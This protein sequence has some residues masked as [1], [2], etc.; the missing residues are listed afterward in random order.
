MDVRCTQVSHSG[1]MIIQHYTMSV[2]DREGPVYTG[3]TYFGFFSETALAQQV[4]IRGVKPLIDPSQDVRAE[5]RAFP[6]EAPFPADALRMLDEVWLYPP[7]ADPQGKPLLCGIKQVNPTDW[8]FQAHFYQDPVWPGS[9]GLEAML[10]LMKVEAMR[11]FGGAQG[12]LHPMVAM[13]PQTTHR[14]SYRGQVIPTCERVRVEARI[15]EIDEVKKLLRADGMLHVDGRA[16]Y[17]MKDFVLA[18][19]AAS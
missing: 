5:K 2:E 14:W 4:G 6:R 12:A 3:K 9:L 13:P 7:D 11:R 17:E 10:Q 8:F 18:W 15:T 1:G 16:I 19:R